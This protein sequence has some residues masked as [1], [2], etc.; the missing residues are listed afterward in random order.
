MSSDILNKNSEKID[1]K[2]PIISLCMP[3]NGVIDWVFPALE[4]IYTQNVDSNLFEVVVTNNGNNTEFDSRMKEYA[5]EHT[6]LIYEK[7]DSYMFYNQLEALKLAKG[8]YLKFVNHRNLLVEG[9]LQKMIDFITIYSAKKPVIYFSNGSLKLKEPLKLDSFDLFV[10]SLKRLVS[11][12]TG[13]GIWKED[14]DKI[15]NNLKVDSISPHS[16]ILFAKRDGDNYVINDFNFAKDITSGHENKGT[17][18]LFKA[19]GVEEP[20]IVL[21]L[22]KEKA[23][24]AKTLKIVLKDYCRFVSELY[25]LFILKKEKCSY[26]LN[27]FEDAMGVFFKKR[28]VVRTARLMRIKRLF[29]K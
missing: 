25:Y 1:I 7:N 8:S 2:K 12:T 14:Y 21:N 19:F 3:T 23:I 6:N 16:C 29:K 10:R 9:S 18:D 17:Y 27:G 24:S 11:W 15:C 13:V 5:K 4:S 20:T 28:K 26:N 22:Y